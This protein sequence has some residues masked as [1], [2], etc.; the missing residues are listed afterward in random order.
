MTLI[1]K[2]CSNAEWA[3]AEASGSY[4]GSEHDWRDGFIHFSTASQLPG[5]LAK[6]YASR[7]DLLLIAVDPDALGVALRWEPARDG[8]LFPHLYGA[9]SVAVVLWTQALK[10]G[11]SG[12]H[13]LP[14]EAMR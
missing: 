5:T 14:A 1:Y 8:D 3:E 13:I 6:H 12:D 7:T 9:L 10:I 2:I 4:S 11:E